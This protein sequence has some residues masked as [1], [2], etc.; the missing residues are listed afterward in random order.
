MKTIINYLDDLKEKL[1]S[2]YKVAKAMKVDQSTISVIRKRGLMSD[3][4]AVK[5]ADLLEIEPGEV[6]IAAAMARSEGSVKEAWKALGKKAGIA[7]GLLLALMI[8]T[9]YPTK[10]EAN[11]TDRVCILC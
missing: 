2:D 1:G 3:E 8:W 9:T 6:L 5:V 4:T 11:L 10:A 7:A